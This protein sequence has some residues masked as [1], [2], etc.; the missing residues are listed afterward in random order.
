MSCFFF[1]RESATEL[2]K[3][4][5]KTI[6]CSDV[7][8]YFHFISV[9]STD[10]CLYTNI[11]ITIW[12]QKHLVLPVGCN[13]V[14]AILYIFFHITRANF[15][16]EAIQR[17]SLELA[18]H[19]WGH[20]RLSANNK[21]TNPIKNEIKPLVFFCKYPQLMCFSWFF[22]SHSRQCALTTAVIMNPVVY[23]FYKRPQKTAYFC[24]SI[25][26]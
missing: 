7:Y 2:C 3:S 4:E 10:G 22:S 9:H 15:D 25:S 18:C 8:I 20:T 5:T 23:W 13:P 12:W 14:I 24:M 11:V 17:T 1:V 19:K 6:S 26:M 16:N 21:R